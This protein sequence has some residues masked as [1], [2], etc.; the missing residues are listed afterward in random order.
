MKIA[1]VIA[2][3]NPFH[4]GH[5]YQLEQIKQKTGADYIVVAMSGDFLQRGVPAL[6]DKYARTKM[7]LSAGADLVI[8]LP[9]VWATASA[10]YFA[11]AGVRLFQKMGNVTHL[12]FGA[13]CDDLDLLLSISSLLSQEDAA[14]QNFLSQNLKKGL[15]FPAARSQAL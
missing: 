5:Y 12:C 4:N 8:E 9:C 3:Y 2:E 15:S 7:A 1:G 11:Q 14:Y 10:E 6:T 13:E